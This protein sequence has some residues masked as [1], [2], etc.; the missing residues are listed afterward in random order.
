MF[1]NCFAYWDGKSLSA[2]IGGG[3]F[4]ASGSPTYTTVDRF[5]IAATYRFP[6]AASDYLTSSAITSATAKTA[7]IWIY[8]DSIVTTKSILYHGADAI[9]TASTSTIGSEWTSPTLYV[10]GAATTTIS[11]GAWI[12]LAVTSATG[13]AATQPKINNGTNTG[14]VCTVGEVWLFSTVLSAAEIAALYAITKSKYIYPF[15][16]GERGCY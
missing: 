12:M 14:L 1:E 3:L 6:T 7:L 16:R 15:Q 4:T 11:S 9:N 5:N 2:V 13:S 10:N 8:I